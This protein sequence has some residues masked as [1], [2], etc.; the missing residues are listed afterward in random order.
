MIDAGWAKMAECVVKAAI[1]KYQKLSDLN[2][3]ITFFTVLDTRIS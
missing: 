1:K 3:K 2:D